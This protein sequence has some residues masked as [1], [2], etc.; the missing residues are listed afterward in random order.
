MRA[1][2]LVRVPLFGVMLLEERLAFTFSRYSDERIS[3]ILWRTELPRNLW[4]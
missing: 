4:L 3:A 1:P 2:E